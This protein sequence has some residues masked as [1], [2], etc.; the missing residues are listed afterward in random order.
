MDTLILGCTHYPLVAP[1]LQRM[2]GRDV[3][4]VT[5]GHAVAARAQRI[6][7]ADGLDRRTAARAPT[8]SSARA[9]S[10]HFRGLGTRFLQM[11]LGRRRAR[12]DRPDA[13]P[14]AA[15][16]VTVVGRRGPSRWT[17]RARCWSE[18]TCRTAGWT[19]TGTRWRRCSTP[20]RSPGA[21]LPLILF[22]RRD[23]PRGARGLRRAGARQRRRPGRVRRTDWAPSAIRRRAALSRDGA[24]ASQARRG[25]GAPD[26]PQREVYDV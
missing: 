25:C 15:G 16:M 4:L 2:L 6:L 12:G 26:R 10:S 24:V 20:S 11:P 14:R 22:P 23:P 9:R 19:S 8:A 21:R 1:M 5:A 18:T 13:D 7:E 17:A 3:R